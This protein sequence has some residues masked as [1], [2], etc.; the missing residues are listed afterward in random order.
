MKY[1]IKNTSKNQAFVQN[2]VY[3]Q[4]HFWQERESLMHDVV[5]M[6]I[7]KSL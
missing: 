5:E 6:T 3:T 7:E 2:I 1:F 4:M